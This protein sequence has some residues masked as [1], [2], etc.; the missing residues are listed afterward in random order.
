MGDKQNKIISKDHRKPLDVDCTLDPGVPAV[1]YCVRCQK[2]FCADCIGYEKGRE[3]LC[4]Q[5]TLVEE[6]KADANRPRGQ[7]L[8]KNSSLILKSL[9]AIA[10]IVSCF[11]LYYLYADHQESVSEPAV[12]AEPDPQLE[13]IVACRHQMELLAAEAETYR[14]LVGKIPETIESLQSMLP[15][16]VDI[17]DPVTSRTY[18]LE[19][20][21]SGTPVIRCPNP[22]EHGVEDISASPGKP[23]RI[24]YSYGGRS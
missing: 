1:F 7:L 4:L 10:I 13:G 24:T 12:E 8:K 11:N 5:C 20:N 23:A 22:E 21:R 9:A 3:I 6:S 18:Q 19:Q 15:E 14:N 17:T 2:P 16:G